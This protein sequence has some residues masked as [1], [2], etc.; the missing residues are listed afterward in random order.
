[1]KTSFKKILKLSGLAFLIVLASFGIGFGGGVP[2]PPLN[3]K[4]D[5]IEINGVT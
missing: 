4:E 1:M 5:T 3:K 2:I